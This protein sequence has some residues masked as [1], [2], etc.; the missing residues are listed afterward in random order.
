MM[1]TNPSVSRWPVRKMR[2]SQC[3]YNVVKKYNIFYMLVFLKTCL[4][5]GTLSLGNIHNIL[6]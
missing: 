1:L 2:F 3:D 5:D 4:A 6:D